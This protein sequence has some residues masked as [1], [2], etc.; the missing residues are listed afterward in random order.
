M[1][2]DMHPALAALIEDGL[3]RKWLGYEELNNALPDAFVDPD[4]IDDVLIVIDR[5]GIEMVDE[6]ELKARRW[7]ESRK[8]A[9]GNAIGSKVH[10]LS[11]EHA[12]ATLQAKAAAGAPRGDEFG[13]S[14]RKIDPTG[15]LTTKVIAAGASP[16]Q[17]PMANGSAA[18]PAPGAGI[19]HTYQED[20]KTRAELERM[21]ACTRGGHVEIVLKDISTIARRPGHLREWAAMAQ[22]LVEN[23]A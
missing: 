17:A 5:L 10:K 14:L 9:N 21:L 20:T 11:V 4:R 12:A 3:S 23:R 18:V 15:G 6:R 8:H 1:I 16:A 13:D 7:R 2:A 22:Q 19:G